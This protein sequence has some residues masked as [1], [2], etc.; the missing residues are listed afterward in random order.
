MFNDA[1]VGALP[2][3]YAATQDVPS[4][5]YVGP[6]G[7]QHLRGNP[8]VHEPAKAATDAQT[9]AR[10]WELSARLTGTDSYLGQR[11]RPEA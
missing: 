6:D 7:F 3:L 2:I 10:L 1:G 4:G 9:A 11:P 5:S 8:Q